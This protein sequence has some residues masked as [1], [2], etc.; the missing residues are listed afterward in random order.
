M[1][2]QAADGREAPV[3]VRTC[4]DAE[5]GAPLLEPG[6]PVTALP[7][8]VR[9]EIA[10][11]EGRTHAVVSTCYGE[12]FGK[13]TGLERVPGIRRNHPERA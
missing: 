6:L 2:Y 3:T 12:C 8:R 7:G 11:F 1:A 5:G 9:D 10:E 13:P 4:R